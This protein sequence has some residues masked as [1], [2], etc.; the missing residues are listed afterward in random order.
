VRRFFLTGI[1]AL[2]E[3]LNS[4][5]RLSTG[6][7]ER[8]IGIFTERQ[9]ASAAIEAVQQH[10]NFACFVNSHCEGTVPG[11]GW[12]EVVEAAY[13]WIELEPIKSVLVHGSASC[14]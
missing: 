13:F 4:F 7:R 11:H 9:T 1:N 6:F 2:F 10:E 12:I 14:H 8:N 3:Q 5:S